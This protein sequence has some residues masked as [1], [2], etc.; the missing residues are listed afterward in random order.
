MLIVLPMSIEV[1]PPHL[2]VYGLLATRRS[3]VQAPLGVFWDK[4]YPNKGKPL[5]THFFLPWWCSGNIVAFQAIASGSIPGWGTIS[6]C[7][8]VGRA[9]DCSGGDYLQKQTFARKL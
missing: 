6:R 5:T 1:S 8:S 9:V 3:R 7:S 4:H 2:H